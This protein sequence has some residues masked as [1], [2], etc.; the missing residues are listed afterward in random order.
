[1]TETKQWEI[2][3]AQDFKER[4]FI[5]EFIEGFNILGC[6]PI[7]IAGR[8]FNEPDDEKAKIIAKAILGRFPK[9]YRPVADLLFRGDPGSNPLNWTEVPEMEEEFGNGR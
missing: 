9:M 3:R 2:D 6:D 4:E 1:M 5:R 7:S 8:I